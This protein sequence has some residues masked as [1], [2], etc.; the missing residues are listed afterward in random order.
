MCGSDFGRNAERRITDWKGRGRY[1][2]CL[3][4]IEIREFV[5]KKKIVFIAKYMNVKIDIY[6]MLC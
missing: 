1:Q 6:Y 2:M 5:Q 4:L 3:L